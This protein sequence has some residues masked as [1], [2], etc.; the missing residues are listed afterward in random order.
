MIETIIFEEPSACIRFRAA[1]CLE[2]REQYL[3]YLMRKGYGPTYLRSVS[4]LLL[5]VIHFLRLATLRKVGLDE[6]ERATRAWVA[7]RGP[8]RRGTVGNTT[9]RFPR[10]AKNW[11]HFH[12]RLAVPA[13]PVHP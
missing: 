11:L 10:V 4:G 13:A 9:A 6:I 2:E 12:G 7:Y 8:D 3:F 5:R 1:P